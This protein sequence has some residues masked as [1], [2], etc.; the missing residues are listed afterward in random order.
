MR[1]R[2][3]HGGGCQGGGLRRAHFQHSLPKAAAGEI[4]HPEPRS[5]QVWNWI[6]AGLGTKLAVTQP[7]AATELWVLRW[8]KKDSHGPM[9]ASLSHPCA[10]EAH[11]ALPAVL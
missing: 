5:L 1:P 7:S 11:R 2:R 10:R 9:G 3:L 4:S 8:G 6:P